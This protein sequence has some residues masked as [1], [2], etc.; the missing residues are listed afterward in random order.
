MN[1]KVCWNVFLCR[2]LWA[3]REIRR[4][5]PGS[6]MTA[7]WLLKRKTQ[8]AS[9]SNSRADSGL[10]RTGLAAGTEVRYYHHPQPA[11]SWPLYQPVPVQRPS[12]PCWVQWDGERDLGYRL[13]RDSHGQKGEVW[14]EDTCSEGLAGRPPAC[15]AVC[16]AQEHCSR[17]HRL[18]SHVDVGHESIKAHGYQFWASRDS[19]LT[20][21]LSLSSVP[22]MGLGCVCVCCI[23]ILK[24]QKRWKS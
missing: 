10:P 1:P 2:V 21:S 13:A 23:S 19:D 12:Q 7:P 24:R 16:F 4:H 6:T 14:S 5:L 20:C 17:R 18:G 15:S 3:K 22:T 11:L 8:L 9:C